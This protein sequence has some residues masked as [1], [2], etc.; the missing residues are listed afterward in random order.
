MYVYMNMLRKLRL[1]QKKWFSYKKKNKTKHV[2]PFKKVSILLHEIIYGMNMLIRPSAISR[3]IL[4]YFGKKE[5][6]KLF[7]YLMTGAA[8]ERLG[9]FFKEKKGAK[10]SW[11]KM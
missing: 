1:R 8:S 10:K 7:F 4:F 2:A 3:G 6:A 5:G 9:K 11:C